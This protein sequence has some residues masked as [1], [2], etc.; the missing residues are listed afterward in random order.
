MKPIL[1]MSTLV[2]WGMALVLS[3]SFLPACG[4]STE[5]DDPPIS[6]IART[7]EN[8]TLIE[9][10]PT[11]WLPRLTE[12]GTGGGGGG[13]VVTPPATNDP[14]ALGPAFP[15]PT[16]SKVSLQFA[17]AEKANVRIWVVDSNGD[18]VQDLVAG[19]SLAAGQFTIDWEVRD[20]SGTALVPPGLY[21]VH[22]SARRGGNSTE[23]RSFGDVMVEL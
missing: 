12:S 16:T 2:L 21:R 15:N 1:P 14:L 23:A 18:K 5:P 10:D 11:D 9:D 20:Q 19:D 22:F 4:G 17:L 13:V 7:A 6:G 3:I 8:G